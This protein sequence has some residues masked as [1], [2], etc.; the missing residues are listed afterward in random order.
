MMTRRIVNFLI[1]FLKGFVRLFSALIPSRLREEL[2]AYYRYRQTLEASYSLPCWERREKKRTQSLVRVGF[3]GA[4]TF[5][6]HH[7][8]VL[9]HLSGVKI[10]AI[11]TTGGPRVPQVAPRYGI[12]NVFTR[13]E[14]FL[15]CQKVFWSR[16]HVYETRR[17][18]DLSRN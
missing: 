1:L 10:T 5:A 18:F 15:T 11:L 8:K 16:K 3:V 7:L 6:Q 13:P 9:S 4:G 12:E 14:D 17:L 2:Q